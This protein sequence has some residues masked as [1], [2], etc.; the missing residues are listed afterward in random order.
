MNTN[1]DGAFLKDFASPAQTILC[2]DGNDGS[3]NT[4]ARYTLNVLPPSWISTEK[5]PARRHL[6]TANYLFADGHVKSLR[7]QSIDNLPTA[8][9]FSTFSIR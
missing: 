7:P 5:S 2:G 1:C 6:D 4:N 3:E 9:S 8:K